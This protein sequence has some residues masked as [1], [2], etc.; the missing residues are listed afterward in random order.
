M[1]GQ[2]SELADILSAQAADLRR[3]LSRNLLLSFALACA[4]V[5]YGLG[6]RPGWGAVFGICTVMFLCIS[7]N[8][9]RRSR[10]YSRALPGTSVSP[11]YQRQRPLV[12][13]G[14]DAVGVGVGAGAVAYG[15]RRKD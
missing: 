4:A 5:G 9:W 7:V 12:N 6:G 3:T 11:Q 1:P 8:V 14:Q 2:M 15:P 13:D 10:R